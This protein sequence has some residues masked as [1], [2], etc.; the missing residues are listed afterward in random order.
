MIDRGARDVVLTVQMHIDHGPPVF[1]V[2][3]VQHFVAQN[4]GGVDHGMQAA[5]GR[6]C[7]RHHR[8]RAAFVGHAVGI[9]DRLTAE[10]LDLIHRFVRGIRVAE[11]A[12]THSTTEIF[13]DCLCAFTRGDQ[14]AITAKAAGR[15]RSPAQPCHQEVPSLAPFVE[16][17]GRA[18]MTIDNKNS[19]HHQSWR[20]SFFGTGLLRR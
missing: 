17:V 1:V 3:F 2:H 4:A 12:S 11:V 6:Q 16:W 18:A 8:F 19:P 20:Q 10:A 7:H 5:E 15:S 14:R 9:R 13:D